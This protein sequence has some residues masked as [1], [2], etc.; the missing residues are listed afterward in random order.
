MQ[1]VKGETRQVLL[2]ALDIEEKARYTEMLDALR[3]KW[4]KE[5]LFRLSRSAAI[6]R[7]IE[8]VYKAEFGGE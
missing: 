5:G 2:G 8:L 6:R 3:N 1:K 7:C 4:A